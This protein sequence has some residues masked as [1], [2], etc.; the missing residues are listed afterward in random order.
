MT[1]IIK[2]L[3]ILPKRYGDYITEIER[4]QNDF[5]N[6]FSNDRQLH[7]SMALHICSTRKK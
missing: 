7:S 6:N 5:M 2:I 3:E 4:E 1:Q